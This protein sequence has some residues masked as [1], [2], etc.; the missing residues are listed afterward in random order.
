MLPI[1]TKSLLY[2]LVFSSIDSKIGDIEWDLRYSILNKFWIFFF[3]FFYWLL[4]DLYMIMNLDM[5][6]IDDFLALINHGSV[7][8]FLWITTQFSG[9]I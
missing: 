3:F 1:P 2:S 6:F 7:I 9:K 8:I 5:N 4:Q